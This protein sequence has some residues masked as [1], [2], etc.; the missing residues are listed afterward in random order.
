MIAMYNRRGGAEIVAGMAA[1]WT[2]ANIFFLLFGGIWTVSAVLVGGA[3]GAG[4][5]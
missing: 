4:K 1:G 3:L 2:I 5:L